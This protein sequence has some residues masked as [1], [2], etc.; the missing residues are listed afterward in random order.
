MPCFPAKNL[1]DNK[2]FILTF[3]RF[4]QFKQVQFFTYL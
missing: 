2:Y 4:K 3:N 1:I